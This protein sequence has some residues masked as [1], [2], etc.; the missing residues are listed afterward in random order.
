[1]DKNREA[2]FALLRAGLGEQSVRLMP[3]EPLDF[4]ALNK[5]ILR[6]GNFGHNRD[7]SIYKKYPYVVYKAISLGRHIGDSYENLFI[8]LL[9]SL[10][11]LGVMFL[12]GV[13][14]VMKGE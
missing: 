4:D 3:Y 14:A 9:D 11:V 6:V 7:R 13:K 12:D 1:M 5:F 2:F 10:M 8:F